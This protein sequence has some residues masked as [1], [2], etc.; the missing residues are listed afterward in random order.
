MLIRIV[1]ILGLL[2]LLAPVATTAAAAAPELRALAGWQPGSW[3][4]SVGEG[5]AVSTAC[6]AT[7]A[8]LLLDGRGDAG[9]CQFTTIRDTATAASVTYQCSDGRQGRTDLRRD[10]QQVFTLYAQGVSGK[11]PFADRAEWR[12]LGNC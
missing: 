9:S 4:R 8:Q 5:R 1:P 7:P 2:A 11:R 12:R 10:T 3:Q 6:L